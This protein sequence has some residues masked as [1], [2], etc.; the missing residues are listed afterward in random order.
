M[1]KYSTFFLLILFFNIS[2]ILAQE[3]IDIL[4][5]KLEK[6]YGIEKLKILN[7]ITGNYLDHNLRKATKYGKQ[8]VLLSEN[9]FTERNKFVKKQQ[10]FHKVV[11]Y[12][13]LGKSYFLRKKYY[14]AQQIYQKALDEAKEINYRQ[15]MLEAKT[16]LSALDSIEVKQSIFNDKISEL[17]ITQ[18]IESS[19]QDWSIST[20]IR[21]AENS[22]KNANY[23]NAI[24]FYHKAINILKD[25]GDAHKISEL[26]Q[27]IAELYK[28]SGNIAKA[29]KY[30]KITVEEKEQVGDT[31]GL[32]EAI[33]DI[34]TIYDDISVMSPI[35]SIKPLDSAEKVKIVN[36]KESYKNLAKRTEQHKNYKKSLEYY[37][38]YTE[39][40][41]RIEEDK[42]R[43]Q[44]ELL[45]KTY[46]IENKTN[47]IQLL[48]QAKDIQ[49]F[50]L[51]KKRGEIA[52]K[53]KA[54]RNLFITLTLLVGLVLAL[55]FLYANKKRDHNKLHQTNMELQ[56]SQENL[57]LAD[58]KIKTLLDQ[59]VSTEIAKELMSENPEIKKHSRFVCIM[60][61]DIRDFT[62][63]AEKR[64]PE[65]II[66]YQNDVF[67]F[68][69]ETVYSH[70][71]IINQIL[72]DG[73][74]ATFGAPLSKGNDCENA[75]MAA[76]EIIQAVNKKS[77]LGEIPA[78][79]IGIGLHAG[80]VVAGNVG[81][82][83]R[84]QYSITG[85]A[86]IIA[87]R[88][89]QLNKEYKSQ[90]LIS[91]EVNNELGKEKKIDDDFVE[92]VVKGREEPVKILKIV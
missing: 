57:L 90:L 38:L 31:S 68:M 69:I 56:K 41:A 7:Q 37:K 43:Q 54:Q 4:E 51:E 39:L 13:Q 91:E 60:F 55:Y 42:R 72:G 66:Q 8:A 61:L 6:T 19:T 84:K 9:I 36:D 35:V 73:F 82:S 75:F 22:E 92:V 50:E 64:E 81:S 11:A 1:S 89:E 76:N 5:K 16:F 67:G 74:M 58:E 46:E 15:G 14:S 10:Y 78:T 33:T 27:K 77:R 80:M 30:Y 21:I 48:K 23:T 25:K 65:E 24:K 34:K 49:G 20:N 47:E 17:K 59:Q 44:I 29:M 28:K 12:N 62:K 32:K 53:N 18:S 52:K 87:S 40:N 88:I 63:F 70:H 71:G 3:S 86:V 79:R 83:Q 26:H 85:N 45:E 2:H